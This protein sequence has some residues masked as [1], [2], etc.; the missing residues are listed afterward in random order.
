MPHQA[1]K[2]ALKNLHGEL[3]HAGPMDEELRALLVQLDGDIQRVL[4]STE[5]AAPASNTYGL[6]ERAQEI[7][8]R[9][10][11]RHPKLEPALRELGDALSRIGI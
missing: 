7:G 10:A 11:A 2:S 3:T 8:A 6:A 4:E 1:L 9:F 5:E